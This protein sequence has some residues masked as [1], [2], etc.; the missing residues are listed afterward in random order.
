MDDIRSP[1]LH[2]LCINTSIYKSENWTYILS[3][4]LTQEYAS[5]NRGMIYRVQSDTNHSLWFYK[6]EQVG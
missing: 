4:S 5:Q 2:Q 1:G 3:H 6:S